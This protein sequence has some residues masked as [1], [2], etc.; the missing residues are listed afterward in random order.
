MSD[1]YLD[2]LKAHRKRLKSKGNGFGYQ[3]LSYDGISNSIVVGGMGREINLI[4]DERLTD[5]TPKSKIKGEINKEFV[6]SL[7]P[8]EWARLQGFPDTFNIPVSDTQTIW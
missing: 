2:T 6:R 3:I 8:R 5:F 4:I 7:T 1:T